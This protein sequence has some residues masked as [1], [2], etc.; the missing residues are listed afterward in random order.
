MDRKALSIALSSPLFQR[1]AVALVAVLYLLPLALVNVDLYDEG[2]RLYGGM[3]VLQGA[4]PYHDFFAYY[5]PAEFYWPAALF[6]VFGEQLAVT[7]LSAV[8]F[9]VGAVWALSVLLS[10]GGV[11]G[12]GVC[13]TAVAVLVPFDILPNYALNPSL[14]L[15]LGA[16]AVIA[17]GTATQRLLIAGALLGAASAFRQD[18]GAYAALAC[19]AQLG[20]I[21]WQRGEGR[22]SARLWLKRTALVAAA[23]LFVAALIY[24]PLLARGVR[25][26]WECLVS[27]LARLMEYRRY[28]YRLSLEREL[29]WLSLRD[30]SHLD[31]LRM[32]LM[33]APVTAAFALLPLSWAGVRRDIGSER[34]RGG[35]LAFLIVLAAGLAVYAFGRSDHV[36]AYPLYIAVVGLTFLVGAATLRVL[37]GPR[38]SLALVLL[39]ALL[40]A[41]FTKDGVANWQDFAAR[42]PAPLARARG[43]RI[44]SRW[45]WLAPL[46]ADVQRYAAGKPIFVASARHDRVHKSMMTAYFLT[47]HASATYY[48]DLMP[49][50]T[51]QDTVQTRIIADLEASDAQAVLVW[52][53]VLPTE[54][55]LSATERGSKRLDRYLAAHFQLA[56]TRPEYRVLVRKR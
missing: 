31:E 11:G 40:V 10:R 53:T 36:H 38:L 19:V 13:G 49:G 30:A 52:P 24:G 55:N 43:L 33:L 20:V 28:P 44:D 8:F 47:G 35:A 21:S 54:P 7:R 14:T 6:A 18:F 23:A 16:A 3:R 46:V 15:S 45:S 22:S 29:L 4:R 37:G 50:L 56:V 12:A 34:A 32:W 17:G 1:I 9:S 51:T 42:E 41:A 48:P 5:G 27:E 39:L 2:I 26:V 25:V